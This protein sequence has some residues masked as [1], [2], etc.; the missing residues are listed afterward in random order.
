MSRRLRLGRGD[1]IGPNVWYLTRR[2]AAI[3]VVKALHGV[4]R[5][6]G[7]ADPRATRTTA[8]SRRFL[9]SFS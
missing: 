1:R 3:G 2:G 8:G 5:E 9:R 6:V 7:V 4:I